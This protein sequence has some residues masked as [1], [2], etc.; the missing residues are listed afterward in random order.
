MAK[1]EMEVAGLSQPITEFGSSRAYVLIL[2]E[3]E[4]SRRLPIVIGQAEGLA[5]NTEIQNI[6]PPRP[7]THDLLLNILRALDAILTEVTIYKLQDATFYA[8]LLLET[9]QGVIEID[10]RPS[11]GV[12][13]ALRA[14][15]PIYCEEEVLRKAAQ[16]G[17]DEEDEEE[18]EDSPAEERPSRGGSAPER[19]K[20]LERLLQ[21]ALAREDYEMAARIRDELRRLQGRSQESDS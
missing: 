19:I 3:K 4:G 10:C 14:G 17:P 18:T 1:V 11:D 16:P 2:R 9:A 5:I 8:Y 6:R 7:L 15:A 13:L 21:E 12:A 20:E